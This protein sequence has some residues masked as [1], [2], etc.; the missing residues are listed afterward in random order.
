MASV[1]DQN[2]TDVQEMKQQV[3]Q[4]L[5]KMTASSAPRATIEGKKY[6]M[7][8]VSQLSLHQHIYRPC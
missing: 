2:Q 6:S 7:Q 4:V 8:Y 1:D 3:R 5:K